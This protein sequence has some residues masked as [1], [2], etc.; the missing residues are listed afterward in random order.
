MG[1]ELA[2]E[3]YPHVTRRL[4]RDRIGA[5]A[6][7]AALACGTAGIAAAQGGYF[8][9]AWGWSAL[10]FLWAAGLTLVLPTRINLSRAEL[11]FLSLLAAFV[12]WI[13]LSIVWSASV[14]QSIDE[15]ERSIVYVAGATA[16]CLIAR[17]RLIVP[18][19]GAMLTGLV[20]VCAY[21]LATRLFPERLAAA[22]AF[23][24]YRLY[25]PVGYW[26]ALGLLAAIAS[27]LALGFCASEVRL[28]SRVAA[29]AVLPITMT[30]LYFTY[31]RGAWLAL[32]CGL[33]VA[34]VLDRRRLR[35]VTMLF[36]TAPAPALTVWLASRSGALTHRGSSLSDATHEGHRLAI[37]VL[38]FAAL[39]AVSMLV[40]DRV[41]RRVYIGSQVRRTYATILVIVAVGGAFAGV[42][43]GGGPAHLARKGYDRFVSKPEN[44]PDLSRRLFDLSSNGRVELWRS[45]CHD[46]AAH[47]VLGGGAGSFEEYWNRHRPTTQTVRDAHSLYME[48]L[49][50]LGVPGLLLLVAL[51]AVPFAGARARGRPLVRVALG[52]YVA[53]LIHAGYDWDWEMPAVTL[54]G[55]F[56]GLVA[57]VAMRPE[58]IVLEL[59]RRARGALLGVLTVLA[60][61]AFVTLVGNISTS[62]SQGALNV[63]HYEKA[64]KEARRAT[65]WA[66][67]AARPWY[68]LAK[69][70]EGAGQPAAAISSIRKAVAKDSGNYR[71]W[72]E[73][74]YLAKGPERKQAIDQVVRL[75]PRF[76][77]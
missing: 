20:A 44:S 68:L 45:A 70:E 18:L 42:I 54:V 74:A 75:N 37:W 76:A 8:P 35:I 25:Q 50:E 26:N 17:Q 59:P 60:A 21:A 30:T 41:E 39:G 57:L 64:V 55:V 67:W 43:L 14:P 56:C 69:A 24:I 40:T 73:L 31:S 36:V 16:F 66:P 7:T 61:F 53:F 23:Q 47:P 3:R 28:A 9:A 77:P 48:T 49:A 72:F 11:I 62:R 5:G 22:G 29:A 58:S 15:V 71:Y 51:L 33:A 12:C 63:Q 52:C 19:L 27:L 6:A 13:A 46:F 32:A 4:V 10:A 1:A 34:L 38:A 2:T 65:D